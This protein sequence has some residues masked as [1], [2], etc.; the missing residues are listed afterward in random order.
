MSTRDS[1]IHTPLSELDDWDLVYEEQD[2]RGL[3]A[4]DTSGN[5]IGKVDDLI[6]NTDTQLIE[7]V[8]LDDGREFPT[9]DIR[10]T[11]DAVYINGVVDDVEGA[12]PET[13]RVYEDVKLNQRTA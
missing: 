13:V 5:E 6:A 10:I 11:E 3:S 12:V 2:V 1:A 7:F 4:R 9:A 8:R